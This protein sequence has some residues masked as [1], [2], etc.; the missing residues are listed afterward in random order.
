MT[1]VTGVSMKE[2]VMTIGDVRK[3]EDVLMTEDVMTREDVQKTGVVTRTGSVTNTMIKVLVLVIRTEDLT[4][5]IT[6]DTRDQLKTMTGHRSLIVKMTD[7]R[8][9]TVDEKT[10][11]MRGEKGM[12][13]EESQRKKEDT[14]Q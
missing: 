13:K 12:M 14:V 4:V 5:I 3:I 1:I 8:I 10:G 7:T 2:D 11:G 6:G 9:M